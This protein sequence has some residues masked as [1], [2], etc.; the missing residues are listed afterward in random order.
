MRWWHRR[1]R[2]VRS[3]GALAALAAV[4]C[5][6][7]LGV[8]GNGGPAA[9]A[10]AVEPV[11]GPGSLRLTLHPWGSRPASRPLSGGVSPPA[12]ELHLD[13]PLSVG[14]AYL[15][16]ALTGGN[17]AGLLP[18]LRISTTSFAGVRIRF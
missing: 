5:W 13:T 9:G 18:Y 6:A 10:A 1:R 3:A 7:R 11:G 14:A 8:A 12:N 4:V 2:Q 16:L 15:H 17:R